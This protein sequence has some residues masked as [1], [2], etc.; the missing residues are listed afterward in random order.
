MESSDRGFRVPISRP[1]IG[2]KERENVRKSIDSGWITQGPF[3]EECEEKLR[4]LTGRKYALCVSSGTT[5]LMLALRAVPNTQAIAV[6][7][8]TFC[9]V[10]NAVKWIG[11]VED[12]LPHSPVSW[13]VDGLGVDTQAKTAV[14]APCY[15]LLG[16]PER[17][18]PYSTVIEDAAESF[19]G[20]IAGK[21]AGTLGF[22][23]CLSFYANKIVTSGEGG[24]CLT[25]DE[26]MF[27]KMKILSNHGIEPGDRSYKCMLPGGM[28]GRMTDLQAAVLSAQLDRYDEMLTKRR[29]IMERYTA[30]TRRWM[31]PIPAEN[32]TPAPWLFAG[33]PS[34]RKA[35]IAA[36]ADL[37]VEWRPIF[38][39][40]AAASIRDN[41]GVAQNISA[42]GIVL[43]LFSS[44][45]DEQVDLVCK[46]IDQG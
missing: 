20:S 42:R 5:A 18:A 10:T 32:E 12:Y 4:K 19:G 22:I 35:V 37:S 46:V 39:V 2:D 9:A 1:D 31:L 34:D 21:P 11:G 7:I 24:V 45:T 8:L 27:M 13:Q 44:M 23:S 3:V 36:C 33:I 41:C 17:Y 43:P 38:P 29:K 15:G 25:D 6:P 26:P 16:N 30:A 40:S 14:M 28:N